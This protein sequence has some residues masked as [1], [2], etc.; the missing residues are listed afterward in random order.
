MFFEDNTF[1][2]FFRRLLALLLRKLILFLEFQFL[3]NKIVD[4]LPANLI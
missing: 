4:K 1:D 2:L 3:L